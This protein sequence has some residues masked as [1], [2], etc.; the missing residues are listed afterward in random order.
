MNVLQKYLD[1]NGITKYQVSKATGISSMTL[2]HATADSKPLSGQTVKVIAAVAD[3]LG[4]TPGTVLDEL[5][6]IENKK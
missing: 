4:K 2:S 6:E 5:I 1:Q 3:A